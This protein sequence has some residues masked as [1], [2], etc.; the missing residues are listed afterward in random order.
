MYLEYK[1]DPLDARNLELV[2]S[3]NMTLGQR[4]CLHLRELGRGLVSWIPAAPGTALRILA[5]R[6][7]FKKASFFRFGVGV[8]VLGFK[9]ISLGHGVA[10][11]RYASLTADRGLIS[12]G[13]NVYVGDFCTI[14]GDDGEVNIGN[15]VLIAAY[16]LIQAAN[17]KFDRLDIPIMDQGHEP[18]YVHIEDDVWIG[19]GCVICPGVRIGTG[20]VVGAG[21]VVT[22][23]VP[24]YAVV[25]GVPAKVIRYRNEGAG[26][27]N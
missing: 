27:E 5:Y 8:V 24:P 1:H 6:P 13:D 17:H 22:K 18:S 3:E 2:A 10:L 15:N 11:N 12:L 4:I 26:E 25:G 23:D 14:S 20:A 21:A 9:N 16:T 7:F 19:A